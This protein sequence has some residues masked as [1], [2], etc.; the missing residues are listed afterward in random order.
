MRALNAIP[1]LAELSL[2]AARQAGSLALSVART[3]AEPVL[4]RSSTGRESGRTRNW[5]PPS[6][7]PGGEPPP[8]P[9]AP[10]RPVATTPAASASATATPTPPATTPPRAVAVPQP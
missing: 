1:R 2:E 5:E 9:A 3:V 10:R 6:S 7:H 4:G 8:P